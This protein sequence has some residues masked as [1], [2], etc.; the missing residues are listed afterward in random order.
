MPRTRKTETTEPTEPAPEPVPDPEA[1]PPDAAGNDKETT[2]VGGAPPTN[3]PPRDGGDA[4]QEPK[5]PAREFIANVMG[6]WRKYLTAVGAVGT[7]V[8]GYDLAKSLGQGDATPDG[9]DQL[10]ILLSIVAFGCGAALVLTIPILLHGANR[11]TLADAVERQRA[12]DKFWNRFKR[13]RQVV[14]SE[15]LFGH[16][17][18]IQFQE[19]MVAR[20]TEARE[21]YWEQGYKVP[22]RL[23]FGIKQYIAQRD[24]AQLYVAASQVRATSA[25]ATRYAA[26][27]LALAVG[28]YGNATYIANQSDRRAERNDTA[29]T[30][31]AATA[32][33]I[34]TAELARVRAGSVLPV[35]PVEV[36]VVFPDEAAAASAFGVPPAELDDECWE[37]GRAGEAYDLTTAS[38]TTGDDRIVLVLLEATSDRC[39]AA[40]VRAAP[41]WLVDP[42]LPV[43]PPTTAATGG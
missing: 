37:L 3:D 36:K 11:A 12:N 15:V 21:Q 7:A 2:A 35:V 39:R 27:G 41:G 22:P 4:P 34:L 42:D 10:F 19:S 17:S 29:E 18:V 14:G 40:T 31:A 6:E 24:E 30:R 28:G 26:I 25:R 13:N 1:A 23:L 16:P 32:T 5:S 9:H 43:T 33:Q 8:A 38:G 20:L